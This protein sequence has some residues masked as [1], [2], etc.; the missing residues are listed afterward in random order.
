MPLRHRVRQLFAA[1][2]GVRSND[3]GHIPGGCSSSLPLTPQNL[4]QA[5]TPSFRKKLAAHSGRPYFI[6]PRIPFF[7]S[8]SC[9]QEARHAGHGNN[10]ASAK[11]E[12]NGRI[13]CA[14]EEREF[15]EPVN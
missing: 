15:R 12:H 5:L 10:L 4:S 14:S 11:G 2:R 7:S 1:R 13:A 3:H 8:F 6:A 9:K